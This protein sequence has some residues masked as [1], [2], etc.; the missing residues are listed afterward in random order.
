MPSCSRLLSEQSRGGLLGLL[1]QRA[2]AGARSATPARGVGE[3]CLSW[4]TW[5]HMDG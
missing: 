2:K 1:V 5:I 4:Y 3:G